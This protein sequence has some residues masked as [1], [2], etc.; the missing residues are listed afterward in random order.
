MAVVARNECGVD[1][2]YF[3]LAVLANDFPR[4]APAAASD[5]RG[6]HRYMVTSTMAGRASSSEPGAR[7]GAL[8]A[9]SHWHDPRAPASRYTHCEAPLSQL[10]RLKKEK[11]PHCSPASKRE[12]LTECQQI[13]EAIKAEIDALL[14]K[15]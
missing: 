4:C 9:L 13:D 10:E 7:R 1:A 8:T 15:P 2:A 5:S 12:V 3:R 11:R 14:H 6:W